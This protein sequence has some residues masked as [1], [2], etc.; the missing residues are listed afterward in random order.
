MEQLRKQDPKIVEAMNLEVGRQRN[1]IELIASENFVSEAVLQA[2]GTVLTNKYAEG[3]P[4]KRYYGG[5]EY[6]DIV[7]DIARERAKELFGAEH[8][9]VQPH[10][11]AQANMA[12]YLAAL[13]AGDT[14]LGM[15]L[16]HGGH[17]THGSP[18]NASGI[19]YN[20][21]SYG[22][23]ESD[24][25]LDYDEV[26]KLAFKHKPRMIVAGASAYPRTIDFESLASIANDVGAL[27]FVDM[28]HIAGLVAADQHPSPVPH[29]HFVT[30]TTHK[31][32]R[33]PRGGMI[34]CRKP[35]AAAIDKAVFPGTQGGPLMHVI[36]AKAVSFGEALQP[37]FKVYA[38]Q[39]VKNAKALSEALLAEGV[40]L[41][42]GG[43]DNHLM[44]IDLRS[45]DITGKDAEHL[46]DEVGVTVNK[47]AIPFDPAKPMITSGIRIGTAAVTS[48]GMDE[49]AMQ[50]IAKIIALTLKNPSDEAI[51]EKVRDMV[52]DV[53]AQFP[54]YPGL[55]Y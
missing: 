51:H 5:C 14:V 27:F 9:N 46:L 13:K 30:T 18:V 48:R 10:S 11:G 19:L 37:D 1:K 35:W 49:G 53:S 43:T 28:A 29:A 15:S 21:V 44:L 8:V 54:L 24:A 42:S 7:E 25:R 33:G 3:Y 47:N 20:F 36:A 31:T 22:V 40:N 38:E 34:L 23:R 50:V 52:K 55:Q 17:L 16:A 39:V 4:G 2:M 12:V 6:V 45:L 41:V 32:L 26:R